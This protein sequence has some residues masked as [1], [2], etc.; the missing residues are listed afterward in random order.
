MNRL[1]V[2][3]FVLLSAAAGRARAQAGADLL[4][5][6]G[7]AYELAEYEQARPLLILGL[8]PVSGPRDSLW[9]TSVHRLVHVLLD[10]QRDSTAALWLRWA[11]RLEPR[12]GVDTVNFPPS[13][14]DAF[15]QA[16]AV[17]ALA[18]P[19]DTLTETTWEW[20]REPSPLKRGALRIQ[21]SN[22]PMSVYIDGVGIVTPGE[23]HSLEPGS[24]AITVSIP[25]AARFRVVRE[26]LPGIATIIKARPRP[27]AAPPLGLVSVS[28]APWAFL[29]IDSQPIGYTPL[30]RQPVA[31]GAHVLRL[32]HPGFVPFDTTIRVPEHE[33]LDLG[34][35]RLR[36]DSA[37]AVHASRTPAASARDSLAG[38]AARAAQ[39]G[40]EQWAL[41][42]FDSAA[43]RF[44][45]AVTVSPFFAF[46]PD[47]AN[48][49]ILA[50]FQTTKRAT[51]A[52]GV[53]PVADTTFA[54]PLDRWPIRVA[55]GRPATVRVH[56]A[57]IDSTKAE[58]D[59]LLASSSVDSTAVLAFPLGAA[60]RAWP[61]GTYRLTLECSNPDGPAVRKLL[62]FALELPDTLPHEPP[63]APSQFLPESRPGAGSRTSLLRGVGFAALAAA[64]PVVLGNSVLFDGKMESRA[65]VVGIATGSAGVAGFFLGRAHPAL[66]DNIAANQ[67]R[68]AAWEVRNQAIARTNAARRAGGWFRVRVISLP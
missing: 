8:N 35:V 22:L 62:V 37:T 63:I 68:R 6:A 67:A 49:Q 31:P 40:V 48:P 54:S 65:L 23:P 66:P 51:P 30:A 53:E 17:V 5:R 3:T 44:A 12:L 13:V 32:V 20:A 43:T 11:L 9:Q 1:I 38:R 55:V 60:E 4:R 14:V 50:V 15:E 42:H 56:L 18:G 16:Q 64:V 39:L 59:S 33:Q 34:S 52:L 57:V 36:E 10:E 19:G 27:A 29:T 28:S 47:S 21:R 26:V 45:M 41:G 58:R 2:A 61:M 24:Y 25:G 46:D 7:L